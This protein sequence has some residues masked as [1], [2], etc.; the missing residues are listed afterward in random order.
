[1]VLLV[2]PIFAMI[3]VIEGMNGLIDPTFYGSVRRFLCSDLLA[4]IEVHRMHAALALIVRET[5]SLGPLEWDGVASIRTEFSG[6]R[7]VTAGRESLF[8]SFFSVVAD[9]ME[10]TPTNRDMRYR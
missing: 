7:E 9:V 5:S 10:G 6:C 3:L 1:M 8:L 2:L 4:N